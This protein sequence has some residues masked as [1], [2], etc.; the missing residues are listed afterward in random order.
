MSATKGPPSGIYSEGPRR[1]F[2]TGRDLP[3]VPCWFSSAGRH[4]FVFHAE[5]HL[6]D[7]PNVSPV[8]ADPCGR[9]FAGC[10]LSGVPFWGSVLWSPAGTSVPRVTSPMSCRSPLTGDCR[11]SPGDGSCWSYS[12][13]CP[14]SGPMR[15]LPCQGALRG[16]QLDV[17]CWVILT[18][19]VSPWSQYWISLNGCPIL[20]TIQRVPCRRTIA[21]SSRTG[22]YCLCSLA[23]FPLLRGPLR[24]SPGSGPHRESPARSPLPKS[25]G[26]GL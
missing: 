3:S 7:V 5:L 14:L 1:V 8:P 10:L 13:G 24:R 22:F 12:A 2:F 9:S 19:S 18:R 6:L 11:E 4:I 15:C 23:G 26:G 16:P 20:E 17:S 25:H 21:R